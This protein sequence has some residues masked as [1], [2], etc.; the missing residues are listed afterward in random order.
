MALCEVIAHMTNVGD[1][2]PGEIIQRDYG[3]L[4][5]LRQHLGLERRTQLS[6]RLDAVLLGSAVR[7]ERVPRAL[8]SVHG[9]PCAV[10]ATRF[11]RAVLQGVP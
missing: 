9:G 6:S 2:A 1:E 11:R 3:L 5:H 4:L 8:G 7:R 10:R